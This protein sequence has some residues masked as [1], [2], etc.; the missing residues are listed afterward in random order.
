MQLDV[1]KLP[2][3]TL[4]SCYLYVPIMR[5]LL[6]RY[7]GGLVIHMVLCA[8]VGVVMVLVRIVNHQGRL[9]IDTVPIMRS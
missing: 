7:N 4:G 3:N 2:S 6:Y 9:V 1:P 5:L 8:Q